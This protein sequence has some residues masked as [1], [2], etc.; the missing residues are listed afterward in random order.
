MYKILL[1]KADPKI[2]HKNKKTLFTV[3]KADRK[4]TQKTRNGR[5]CYRCR[6]WG[7]SR[8]EM[9]EM[10]AGTG[11]ARLAVEMESSVGERRWKLGR[12][13]KMARDR[14]RC[15]KWGRSTPE[16]G[17]WVGGNGRML[18]GG[19]DSQRMQVEARKGG[20]TAGTGE[21]GRWTWWREIFGLARWREI[22][23]LGGN[24]EMSGF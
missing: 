6:K 13:W 5:D 24:E 4:T 1:K 9:R 11:G 7:R 21:M 18:V 15:R 16:W 8:P 12:R 19:V 3:K 20:R 22:L 17:K 23:A 2:K 14:H 10:V